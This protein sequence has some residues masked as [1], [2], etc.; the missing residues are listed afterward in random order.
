MPSHIPLSPKVKAILEKAAA[1]EGLSF[2]ELVY[3]DSETS[4][5]QP[6]SKGVIF[7]DDTVWHGDVP[8]DLSARHDDYLYGEEN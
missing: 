5:D 2:E 6:S 8:A 3:Q 7:T 4:T 1:A